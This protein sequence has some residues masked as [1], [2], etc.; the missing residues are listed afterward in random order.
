MKKEFIKNILGNSQK[1]TYR[2]EIFRQRRAGFVL[3]LIIMAII[4]CPLYDKYRKSSVSQPLSQT[5]SNP[6]TEVSAKEI[7]YDL[8]PVAYLRFKG[9]EIGY[10]DYDITKF[11][12]LLDCE[13][14]THDP[15]RKNY[16]YDGEDGRYTA[17]GIAMI[18]NRTWKGH[19][20]IGSK[21]DATDNVDCFYK[22]IGD[23]QGLGDYKESK[24]CWIVKFNP[25]DIVFIKTK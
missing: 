18:T 19:K 8:D 17:A 9:R 7:D 11:H 23:N 6:V 15:L 16:L 4:A 2:R 13:N 5:I 12:Q 24:A 10:D 20:C 3:C 25:N 22:I 1:R 14:G 21:W